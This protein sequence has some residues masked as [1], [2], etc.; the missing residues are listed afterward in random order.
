[1]GSELDSSY[2]SEARRA[3]A[4]A[5]TANEELLIQSQLDNIYN[6]YGNGGNQEVYRRDVDALPLRSVL[7]TDACQ[8]INTFTQTRSDFDYSGEQAWQRKKLADEQS[9][10]TRPS[11]QT[12]IKKKIIVLNRSAKTADDIK[13]LL[14]SKQQPK[15][16]AASELSQSSANNQWQGS[17]QPRPIKIPAEIWREGAKL[18]RA[19][20]QQMAKLKA[21]SNQSQWWLSPSRQKAHPSKLQKALAQPQNHSS[22]STLI[23]RHQQPTSEAASPFKGEKGFDSTARA[24]QNGDVLQASSGRLAQ[25]ENTEQDS[26]AKSRSSEEGKSVTTATNAPK[27]LRISQ[28]QWMQAAKSTKLISR[29]TRLEK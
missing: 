3:P 22:S 13:V 24:A 18:A 9:E 21:A 8:R 4:N 29:V 16:P 17:C 5:R 11:T 20:L 15:R 19:K 7:P 28:Q 2:Q 25:T 26:G 23:F 27:R 14:K 6:I 12:S 10:Q 1:M